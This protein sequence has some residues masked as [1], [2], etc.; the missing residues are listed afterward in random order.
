MST[1][2]WKQMVVEKEIPFCPALLLRL[3]SHVGRCRPAL[4]SA[5]WLSSHGLCV[6]QA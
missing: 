3:V 1:D 4:G 2:P 6:V 5:A